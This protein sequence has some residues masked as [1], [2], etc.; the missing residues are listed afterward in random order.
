[1][2]VNACD[3]DFKS[4]AWGLRNG[5]GFQ[6]SVKLQ[7]Q[8]MKNRGWR[9]MSFESQLNIAVIRWTL[10]PLL[11]FHPAFKSYISWTHGSYLMA[12]D[13]FLLPHFCQIGWV[14][15]WPWMSWLPRWRPEVCEV[16]L[17]D[18]ACTVPVKLQTLRHIFP[19]LGHL[20]EILKWLPLH[21]LEATQKQSLPLPVRGVLRQ[22]RDMDSSGWR[23]A[24]IY[25]KMSLKMSHARPDVYCLDCFASVCWTTPPAGSGKEMRGSRSSWLMWLV[26][27]V[28]KICANHSKPER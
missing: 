28:S 12:C 10:L 1:M 17:C 4:A 21:G 2:A 15:S 6:D 20:S 18:V 3:I 27:R 22:Q 25:S 19:E 23:D 7:E 24:R 8:R 26:K 16:C 14:L 11:H 9:R 13:R 5:W